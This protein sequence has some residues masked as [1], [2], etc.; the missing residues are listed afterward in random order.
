MN[1]ETDETNRALADWAASQAIFGGAEMNIS[2]M[3][4][5][6]GAARYRLRWAG[7]QAILKLYTPYDLASGTLA[8]NTAK[9]R[10]AAEAAGLRAYSPI[11][12]APELLWEGIVPQLEDRAVLYRWVE[13]QPLGRREIDNR[14]A[15]IYAGALWQVHRAE[16]SPSVTSPQPV[17]MDKWWLRVHE[18]F[19]DLPG[20]LLESIPLEVYDAF[21]RLTQAVAADAQAHKRFWGHTPLTPVQG[22]PAPE[23]LVINGDSAL[24]VDWQLY[25]S[26]D[27]AYELAY[28]M[29]GIAPYA[30]QEA[31]DRIAETYLTRADDHMFSR[32]VEIYKRVI[33]FGHIVR[34]LTNVD[35]VGEEGAAH[36]RYYMKECLLIYSR[37]EGLAENVSTQLQQ[38]ALTRLGLKKEA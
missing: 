31:A 13:G 6:D 37:P 11:G 7:E 21:S 15:E 26:G 36:L 2:F 29:W 30:G 28:V 12:L 16:I 18:L 10:A 4:R 24:W 20:P 8:P 3:Y 9:S 35:S 5:R 22:S 14:E 1:E 25:G 27:P 33:P 19:R 23:N 38:W 32:E 17:N 34:L